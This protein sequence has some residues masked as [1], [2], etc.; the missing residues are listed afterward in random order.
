MW[1]NG[2]PL[3]VLY[4]LQSQIKITQWLYGHSYMMRC[5]VLIEISFL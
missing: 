4:F 5:K 1:L 2:Y 3:L